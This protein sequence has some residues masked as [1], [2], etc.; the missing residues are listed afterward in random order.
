MG[1]SASSLRLS[2]TALLDREIEDNMDGNHLV[3]KCTVASDADIRTFSMLDCGATGY[4]FMDHDFASRHNF[5]KYQLRTPRDLD[6]VDGRPIESGQIT[7]VT[8]T[9]MM[10]NGHSEVIFMFLTKLGQYSIILGMLWLRRHDPWVRFASNQV[11]FNS[12]HCLKNCMAGPVT[13]SG[14]SSES[15]VPEFTGQDT[16]GL[17]LVIQSKRQQK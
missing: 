14:I 7:H 13:V 15:P 5:P 2:A 16:T 4:A 9:T 3:L 8:K 17:H 6:V 10:I 11:T 1:R 12:D